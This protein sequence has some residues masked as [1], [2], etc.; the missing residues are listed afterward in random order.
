MTMPEFADVIGRMVDPL[1]RS[2]VLIP[3][4]EAFNN[5]VITPDRTSDGVRML[6]FY[7]IERLITTANVPRSPATL[8]R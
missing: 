3:L 2:T 8:V 5:F 4:K 1:A 6:R 7:A